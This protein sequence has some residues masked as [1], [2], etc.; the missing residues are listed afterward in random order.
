MEQAFSAAAARI[1]HDH[2]LIHWEGSARSANLVAI[3][4]HEVRL[5]LD[6]D[7]VDGRLVARP[8]DADWVPDTDLW[9]PIEAVISD[10]VRSCTT[11]H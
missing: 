9:D 11:R 3:W 2:W 8:D 10:F 7:L 1:R 4:N 6:V 5:P